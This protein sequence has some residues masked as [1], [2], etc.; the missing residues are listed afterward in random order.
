MTTSTIVP[1]LPTSD[2]EAI[3]LVLSGVVEPFEAFE[4]LSDYREGKDLTPWMEARVTDRMA[5][6]GNWEGHPAYSSN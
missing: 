6:M 3:D 4:F 5:S 1:S 2:A